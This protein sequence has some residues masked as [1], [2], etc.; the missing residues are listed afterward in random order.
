M[1]RGK[2]R[3]SRLNDDQSFLIYI[4]SS[5]KYDLRLLPN[6]KNLTTLK[7]FKYHIY[8]EELN[9]EC[10]ARV[11]Y[12]YCQPLEYLDDYRAF[13]IFY[14]IWWNSG[15]WRLVLYYKMHFILIVHFLFFYFAFTVMQMVI[16][17]SANLNLK[18]IEWR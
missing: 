2:R 1:S 4:F 13:F 7:F 5:K 15:S 10:E 11:E 8:S 14:L 9:N 6:N 16:R 18:E 3:W 17:V 12:Y